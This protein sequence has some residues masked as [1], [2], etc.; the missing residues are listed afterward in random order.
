MKVFKLNVNGHQRGS[1]R[2]KALNSVKIKCYLLGC[3]QHPQRPLYNLVSP[4]GKI[5]GSRKQG[6]EVGKT[7]PTFVLCVPPRQSILL[8]AAALGSVSLEVLIPRETLL[9]QGT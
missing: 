3:H 7:L 8:T 9:C 1:S 6:V 5:H 2:E 4:R